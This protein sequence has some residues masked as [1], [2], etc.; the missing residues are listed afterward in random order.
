MTISVNDAFGQAWL[1]CFDDVGKLI[2]G[3]SADEL[4]D[5]KERSQ[6]EGGEAKDYE[7]VFS[8]AL[9]KTFI[10]RCRAKQDTYQDQA[11]VRYQVMG[12]APLNYAAEAQ[13][14]AEQIK[15]YSI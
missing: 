10:F 13:K 8:E 7:G 9:C 12:A 5:L 2:M 11:R 15:L 6:M 1:S 14:L 3:K 4:E